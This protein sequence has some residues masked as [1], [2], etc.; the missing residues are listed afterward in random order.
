VSPRPHSS[1][2]ARDPQSWYQASG[3]AGEAS[4]MP[5]EG[6]GWAQLLRSRQRVRFPLERR[7]HFEERKFFSFD[8]L[9][10]APPRTLLSGRDGA[11]PSRPA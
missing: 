2:Y 8:V 11:G 7:R 4:S 1:R 10:F 3:A 6:A 5:A 9:A